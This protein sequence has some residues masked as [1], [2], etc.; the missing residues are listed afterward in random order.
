L[1]PEKTYYYCCC[2]LSKTFE[3]DQSCA[4]T[5]FKPLPFKPKRTKLNTLCMCRYS[6]A[7]PYCDGSH[8]NIPVDYITRQRNCTQDHSV[9]LCE[10]CGHFNG[11]KS[12]E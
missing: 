4:S 1:D 5:N 9:L 6:K 2:G 3:C 7:I 11:Q 10:S 12:L 8:I